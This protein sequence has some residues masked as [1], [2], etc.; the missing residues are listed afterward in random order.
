MNMS[1]RKN[2]LVG[3]FYR[4]YNENERDMATFE[5]GKRGVPWFVSLFAI[6]V[7]IACGIAAWI[8]YRVFNGEQVPFF[9]FGNK[10]SYIDVRLSL[11]QTPVISNELVTLR[12]FVKNTSALPVEPVSMI[13]DYPSGFVFHRASPILPKN[14]QKNYWEVGSLTSGEELTLIVT[15]RLS[16]SQ[17]PEEKKFNATVFYTPV[18]LS[19]E[20]KTEV[21]AHAQ[22][23]PP[24]FR[25]RIDGSPELEPEEEHT[26]TIAFHS[27]TLD[28]SKSAPVLSL[29]VETPDNFTLARTRPES[30]TKELRWEVASLFTDTQDS[31][32]VTIALDGMF[33]SKSALTTPFI[34]KLGYSLGDEFIT[35][36]ETKFLPSF[37]ESFEKKLAVEFTAEEKQSPVFLSPSPVAEHKI[38]SIGIGFENRGKITM[39]NVSFD[40]FIPKNSFLF[41]IPQDWNTP[42][43]DPIFPYRYTDN[44][45]NSIRITSAEIPALAEI[46]PSATGTI[47]LFFRNPDIESMRALLSEGMLTSDG[48]A[49]SLRAKITGPEH[50]EVKISD[51]HLKLNSD[52]LFRVN[53]SRGEQVTTVEWI[54]ENS[55][56]ELKN[57]RVSAILPESLSWTGKSSVAAGKIQY[58][59]DT[60]EALWTVNRLP[61]SVK[62]ISA[63]FELEA[64][65]SVG[66]S[67]GSAIV[68]FTAT[69]TV[70]G[71]LVSIQKNI[72]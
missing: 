3:E 34:A 46:A 17:D 38:F 60:R 68:T 56:H 37:A 39:Q 35:L 66:D 19:S 30:S 10:G 8:G 9:P 7:L 50:R 51:L 57:I 25:L 63:R 29:L 13:I 40:I 58:A 32:L 45:E 14:E 65:P 21:Q 52:A 41:S 33:A 47:A 64:V 72:E 55:F 44:S 28:R 59:G 20:F 24:Q 5:H 54:L 49:L 23:Y 2:D 69:D 70:T 61:A 12:V 43:S 18:N 22:V 62:S 31:D 16:G 36:D 67:E 11:D 4:S 1:P 6:G 53:T 48:V 26:Y 42:N 27:R 15:G 71:S